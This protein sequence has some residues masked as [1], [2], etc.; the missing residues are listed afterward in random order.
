MEY[1]IHNMI[2]ELEADARKR[3]AFLDQLASIIESTLSKSDVAG[4]EKK[5]LI[6]EE[7]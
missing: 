2:G 7:F 4:N 5:S 6:K 1:P 3:E